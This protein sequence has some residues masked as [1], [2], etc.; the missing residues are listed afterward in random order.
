MNQIPLSCLLDR[1][2]PM[3][4]ILRLYYSDMSIF[5]SLKQFIAAISR[6]SLVSEDHLRS[7][8]RLQYLCLTF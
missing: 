8:I 2:Y 7:V 4:V 1:H 5:L 3:R 6:D